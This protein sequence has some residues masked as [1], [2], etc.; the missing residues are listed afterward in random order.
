MPFTLIRDTYHVR[1]YEPD[2]DSVGFA[3]LDDAQWRKLRT[4]RR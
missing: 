3:A 4:G 2:G 1:G